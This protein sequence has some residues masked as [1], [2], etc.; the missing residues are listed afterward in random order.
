MLAVSSSCSDSHMFANACYLSTGGFSD[1][2]C[3]SSPSP[4]SK[5]T[6]CCWLG[7][8]C[9][10]LKDSR[11]AVMSPWKPMDRRLCSNVSMSGKLKLVS[12]TW[13]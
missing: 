3:V 4:R 12:D 7:A 5:N 6:A 13:P 9:R 11:V 1:V 2:Y 8:P 10:A